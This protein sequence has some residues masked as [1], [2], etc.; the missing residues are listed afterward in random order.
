MKKILFILAVLCFCGATVRSEVLDWNKIEYWCGEGSNKAALVVQ[1]HTAKGMPNPGTLVWGFRWNEGETFTGEDLVRAIA[2]HSND[3]VILTQFTGPMG[4]TLNGVGFAKDCDMLLDNIMYDFE[5][6]ASDPKITFGFYEPTVS[7]GQT[8]APGA[9]A[10]NLVADAIAGARTNHIIDHPLN[11]HEYGYPA[12]DY[13]WWQLS[14][15]SPNMFW[16][17]GWYKGYWSYWC[18]GEDL[19]DMSYSGLG[20]SSVVVSDG[21]VQGWKYVVVNEDDMNND[22][23][24]YIQSNASWLPINYKHE[25][26][27]ASAIDEIS[28]E[29]SLP[30]VEY[31]RLDG[32]RVNGNPTS[33][34]YIVKQDAKTT[35]QYIR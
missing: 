8:V 7:M 24:A 28:T 35:K 4:R 27:Q 6:A 11:Q 22:F 32:T 10:I 31:Y 23:D 18:G 19:N 1:L 14:V 16:N 34:L 13:D 21:D 3:I 5:N 30:E 15:Q 20:M 12:Y 9:E 25:L 26:P 29:E 2:T 17:A 33:G